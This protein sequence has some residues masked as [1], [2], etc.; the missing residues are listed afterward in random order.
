MQITVKIG[1]YGAIVF[2]L[3]CLGVSIHG[4]VQTSDLTDPKLISD[5]RGFAFFWLFLSVVCVAIAGATW[6]IGKTSPE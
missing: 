5:G 6:W 3:I 2:A 1:V 4:F